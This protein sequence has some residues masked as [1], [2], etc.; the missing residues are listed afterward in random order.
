MSDLAILSP[1]STGR[2]PTA[3][4]GD[5]WVLLLDRD[6]AYGTV[7]GDEWSSFELPGS[8]PRKLFATSSG[9]VVATPDAM[10]CRP[11]VG[12]SWIRHP[13][14]RKDGAL[15]LFEGYSP[16]VVASGG[17][18]LDYGEDPRQARGEL[19]VDV[20]LA[21]PSG[22]E[23]AVH[24]LRV[25]G[26]SLRGAGVAPDGELV[27]ISN[28][29]MQRAGRHEL[30][31][32]L[33]AHG[34]LI[35]EID[36]QLWRVDLARSAGTRIG[37]G[38]VS[39][40]WLGPAQEFFAGDRARARGLLSALS[41]ARQLGGPGRY[42]E[43]FGPAR[44]ASGREVVAT[45]AGLIVL[46]DPEADPRSVGSD[47][48]SPW[49]VPPT[50]GELAW[51]LWAFGEE[52]AEGA[53]DALLDG[54]G[55]ETLAEAL[56]LH[57]QDPPG[58]LFE[59]AR[60]KRRRRIAVESAEGVR[61]LCVR[62]STDRL[63]LAQAYGS[64]P[65]G[66]VRALAFAAVPSAGATGDL[67]RARWGARG[68]E[69]LGEAEDEKT[70]AVAGLAIVGLRDPDADVRALAAG[71]CA[72]LQRGEAA[73]E[74]SR[75]IPDDD[76]VVFRSAL[77]ALLELPAPLPGGAAEAARK[78]LADGPPGVWATL[79]LLEAIGRAD[80]AAAVENLIT[81]VGD[82][83][84]R[85]RV[86]AWL[87]IRRRADRT[88]RDWALSLFDASTMVLASHVLAPRDPSTRVA[89]DSLD[90]APERFLAGGLGRE[91]RPEDD[92][93]GSFSRP[94]QTETSFGLLSYF[95]EALSARLIIE[96]KGLT[97]TARLARFDEE[98]L[99][100]GYE[101]LRDL[102]GGDAFPEWSVLQVCG[103]SDEV[104]ARRR[105]GILAEALDECDGELAGRLR[106]RAEL[107]AP[108]G[109]RTEALRAAKQPALQGLSAAF[110]LLAADPAADRDDLEA[111]LCSR[112]GGDWPVAIPLFVAAL[113]EPQGAAFLARFL[114][115]TE[116]G[117]AERYRVAGVLENRW[118]GSEAARG[119]ALRVLEEFAA[120]RDA[121]TRNRIEAV[122]T[123]AKYGATG[124]LRD[125]AAALERTEI[126]P[127]QR[128][129]LDRALAEAGDE[130]ALERLRPKTPAGLKRLPLRALAVSGSLGDIPLLELAKDMHDLDEAEI[131][132]AITAIRA[133]NEK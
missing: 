82:A 125:L 20:Y 67:E 84:W 119:A 22:L 15:A 28:Q 45:S 35:V 8:E 127:E 112:G 111:R 110:V 115:C 96:V 60:T 48:A 108:A 121:S 117:L 86:A 91:V 42:L 107:L 104:E 47:P 36:E 68:V 79:K 2:F 32:S 40:A 21:T 77:A 12:A 37:L 120:S 105:L 102:P 25:P 65:V 30:L 123:S 3:A 73:H 88:P 74:L 38:P 66:A 26:S 75:L 97:R 62:T 93:D 71:A 101:R 83:R 81:F 132:E 9:A 14:W 33:P 103:T 43:V 58:K 98:A 106:V 5:G 55:P 52:A 78:R 17:L 124:P 118:A 72:A 70:Q 11:A 41:A 18:V 53:I 61:L 31:S 80:A 51:R 131:E 24:E 59:H 1:R 130:A 113:D 128:E 16:S 46:P 99:A 7:D 109:E 27:V 56:A 57:L 116:V 6:R 34:S 122:V 23:L 13:R 4:L 133:R 49:V 39:A 126:D 114:A 100:F 76:Y 29:G 94:G 44:L 63:G 85:I 19:V 69:P 10:W 87:A 89:P 129:I 92:E 50:P 64:D 90:E 54:C 95:V